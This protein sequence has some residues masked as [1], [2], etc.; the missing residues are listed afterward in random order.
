[1]KKYLIILTLLWNFISYSQELT[2]GPDI[3]EI[4]FM[5]P[6]ATVLYD[7]IYHSIDFGETVN[8]MDSVSALSN[9]IT[10]ISADRSS[11]SLYYTTMGEVLYY[12][13][14]FGTFGSWQP[15]NGGISYKISSG[16]NEGEIFNSIGSHSIDYGQN[17]STH[18]CQGFFGSTKTTEIDVSDDTAYCI[19]GHWDVIDTLYFFISYDNYNNLEVIKKFDFMNGE[20]V[21]LSRANNPGKIFLYNKNRK[22]LFFTEDFGYNWVLKNKFICPNLPI[23]WI[24]GGRQDGELYMLVVYLQ[25]AGFRRHIYIY[26]SLDYGQSFT[27]YHPIAFGADPVY[28]NFITEDTLVEPGELVQF[29]D[30]SSGGFANWEWDFNNDGVTDSYEQNPTHTYQDT[31]YYSVKLKGNYSVIYDSAIQYNYIHVM[32]LTNVDGAKKVLSDEIS[33]YPNPFLK[34]IIIKSTCIYQEISIYGL[35][36]TNYYSRQINQ[37]S[38]TESIDLRKLEKGIY[39]LKIRTEDQDI[40]KKILKI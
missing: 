21:Q 25:M 17:F 12:S 18:N 38:N 34:S 9:T 22:E 5:G 16:R 35:N 31:G 40:T 1:L 29:T 26:H 23:E 6:T 13:S 8:C 3:G 37:R 39:I 20:V 11:G 7:A 36:G 14:N 2:R 27:V 32:D 24:S 19:S 30:L 4:Y 33:C 28:A 15:H 10:S